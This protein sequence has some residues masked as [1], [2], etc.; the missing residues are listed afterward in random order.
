MAKI[1]VGTRLRLL[2]REHKL[3]QAQMAQSVGI[4]TSY[5]NLLE[6]NQ[7]SLSVKVLMS[8]ADTYDVDW[9]DLI[10]DGS[11]R[12]LADLRTAVQDPLFNTGQPD[13]QELRLAVDHAPMLVENFLHLYKS[14]SNVI[15][16]VMQTGDQLPDGALL[17]SPE[18]IVHDFFRSHSNYFPALEEYAEALHAED[19]CEPDD[20]YYRLKARLRE[21]H[22]ID[23]STTP[24]EEMNRSLR[25]YDKAARKIKLSEALDFPNR[26][27]QLAHML[28][29][30]EC[31]SQIEALTADITANEADAIHTGKVRCQ[32][33]LANYFAAAFLMPYSQFKSAAESLAYDIN[34]LSKTFGASFEQACHRLTTLQRKG[35]RGIPFFFIRVDR[36]GNVT[37]RFNAS[38]I[39]IAEYGGA[40]PV[41]DLHAAFSNP[42][43]VMP[44]FVELPDGKRFFTIS[45]TADRPAYSRNSQA[46]RQAVSLGCDLSHVSNIGYARPFNQ[47]DEQLYAQIGINCR[48]C[49]RQSCAQRAHNPLDI[50]LSVDPSR[51]GDTRLES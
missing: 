29:L 51:R 13:I 39:S 18:A 47:D 50:E 30:I 26:A 8:I 22:G 11:D 40:C 16:R 23:I 48:I 2:R 19:P 14:H 6:N 38:S 4:S 32:V 27:F 37:K 20:V 46:R 33:E 1:F 36:A 25:I 9:R 21:Q 43:T 41:W 5:I 35:D 24:I 44:Q 28:C 10:Q 49:P 7:R 12:L 15:E 42:S 17:T 45:R 34:R 31:N 3:S